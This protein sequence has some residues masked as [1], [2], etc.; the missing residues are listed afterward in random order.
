M[1]QL[2]KAFVNFSSQ[3]KVFNCY[4]FDLPEL[5]S[6]SF[7]SILTSFLLFGAKKLKLSCFFVFVPPFSVPSQRQR[8]R[9]RQKRSVAVF[10][11]WWRWCQPTKLTRTETKPI[12][13]DSTEF[14]TGNCRCKA[15][16]TFSA[17]AFS[18]ASAFH[19]SNE[20]QLFVPRKP[21]KTHIQ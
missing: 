4:F 11:F 16:R 13:P 21:Q 17:I 5:L 8:R 12:Q 15:V 19:N 9:R 14:Q 18:V 20:N 7:G 10:N 6:K 1:L 2:Y 3:K